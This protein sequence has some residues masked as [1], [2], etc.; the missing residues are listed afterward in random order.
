M[1]VY[2]LTTIIQRHGLQ[3]HTYEDDTQIYL[4]CD[5]HHNAINAA[6]IML[7]NCILEVIKW[8]TSNAFKINE[9]KTEF[10]F[11][12]STNI[13]STSYTLQIGDNSIPLSGQVKILGV[14]LDSTMTLAGQI[15]ATCR[16]SYMHIRRINTIRQYLTNDAV[17]NTDTIFG[18]ITFRLLQHHLYGLPMKS[19]KRLQLTQNAAARLIRRIKNRAHITPVLRDLHWLPVV[20]LCQF[21]ILNLLRMKLRVTYLTY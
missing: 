8:M 3:Y 16:S 12:N 18:D 19:I 21:K 1:Y 11:F 10:I 9:E 14:T 15:A 7:Q 17:K 6:I 2:Q 5:N 13:P 20:K 4:Q